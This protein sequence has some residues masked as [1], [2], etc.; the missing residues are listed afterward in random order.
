MGPSHQSLDMQNSKYKSL[1]LYLSECA[2]CLVLYVPDFHFA[3]DLNEMYESQAC[4]HSDERF[5]K[6]SS[7]LHDIPQLMNLLNT[8]LRGSQAARKP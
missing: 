8:S 4:G 3:L 7:K 6:I 1:L 5:Y 2:C